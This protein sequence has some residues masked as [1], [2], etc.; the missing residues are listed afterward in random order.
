[1]QVA[2]EGGEVRVRIADRG[3]IRVRGREL[4]ERILDE[5]VR[6]AS[7]ATDQSCRVRQQRILSGMQLLMLVEITTGGPP[8]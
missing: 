8:S 5:V 6:G 3:Q 2:D 1:M 7:I 4:Y